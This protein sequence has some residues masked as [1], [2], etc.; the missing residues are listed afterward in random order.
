MRIHQSRL[1]QM[2][3]KPILPILVLRMPKRNLVQTIPKH[4]FVEARR[5][6]RGGYVD[7]E[8]NPPI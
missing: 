3:H 4:Q 2:P 7:E 6:N 5:Q 1:P 8:R